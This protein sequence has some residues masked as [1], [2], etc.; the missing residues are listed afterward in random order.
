[1]FPVAGCS[2]MVIDGDGGQGDR[3]TRSDGTNLPTTIGR[4]AGSM[5]DSTAGAVREGAS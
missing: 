4:T 1:M 2:L 3:F 5:N